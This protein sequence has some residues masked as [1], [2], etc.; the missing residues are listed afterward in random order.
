MAELFAV[1]SI[2]NKKLLTHCRYFF[3]TRS[4][5]ST[6][7]LKRVYY[8]CFR[9]RINSLRI[10][11]SVSLGLGASLLKFQAPKTTK[12][13]LESKDISRQVSK[14]NLRILPD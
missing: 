12:S 3:T 4:L 1:L 9:T 2:H 8:S 10:K 14:F 13:L 7:F 6:L 11:I 5:L